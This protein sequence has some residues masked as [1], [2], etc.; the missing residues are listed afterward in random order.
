MKM[1]NLS[2]SF[3]TTVIISA[4]QPEMAPIDPITPVVLEKGAYISGNVTDT[5]G[6][7]IAE[8]VVTDGFTQAVTDNNGYYRFESKY[9]NRAKFVS[10]R[11]PSDYSPIVREGRPVFYTSLQ[12]YTG[13]ERIAN[14]TLQKRTDASDAF[15]MF[16][17]ADPQAKAY[18]AKTETNNTA[19]AAT[20]VWEDL[21]SDMRNRIAATNGN[22]YGIC[23]GDIAATSKNTNSVY[24]QYCLGMASL[25]IP[26]WQVIGNHDHFHGTA[27]ATDD[28]AAAAFEAT[29]G[30][31][32][33]SFDL[34]K[35]HFVVIDN[36]IYIKDL[37]RYPFKYGLED[38]V[39]E[40]LKGDL[41][42]VSKDTP[43]MLCAHADFFDMEGELHSSLV[44][45]GMDCRYKYEEFLQTI[46]SFGFDKMY[47][48]AG[49][50][51]TTSFIGKIN[52]TSNI[53]SFVVGRSAGCNVQ[54]YLAMDGTPR[55]YLVLEAEGKDI[56]WKY[57][58]LGV[59]EA[60][61][62][63]AVAPKYM[64][65]PALVDETKQM[66]VYPRGSYD[67]NFV[68][69]NI[70]L[71]DK[72]WG[73]PYL[74][75][76]GVDYE[77][78]RDFIYDLG[79]KEVVTHYNRH[80][81][82]LSYRGK[83]NKHGFMVR[84]PENVKGEGTVIVTDRF[85]RTWTSNVSVDPITYNDG[86][87]HLVFDFRETPSGCPTSI[88]MD[89]TFKSS[90]YSFNLSCGYHKTG[91]TKED[92]HLF[93][94]NVGS[95]LVLP[96]IPGYKLSGVTI[97]PAGNNMKEQSAKIVDK[98][99]KVV[100]GGALMKF[101]GNGTDS[102]TLEETQENTSYIIVTNTAS[103]NIGELR[104]AYRRLN[105]SGRQGNTDGFVIDSSSDIQF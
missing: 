52:S 83:L 8:A 90:G 102:W 30:P 21:F 74:R 89:V 16:M 48:W 73:T 62:R 67:D 55:G 35:F 40:W 92:N 36:C 61:F 72:H 28:D 58:T 94:S 10:V 105:S 95:S 100:N 24:P 53:E 49:H 80:G 44:Y 25:N 50:T 98:N 31:R 63:G 91:N 1:I 37:R 86:M 22:C 78:T 59:E 7:P 79:C 29:F 18:D 5:D 3:L 9:P 57:H 38:E 66:N 65:K 42:L 93:I 96:A 2:L 45:D 4:C 71:W 88:A 51:H 84:V 19:F 75:I 32:N 33:Y 41:A 56:T 101:Y 20:D 26:F 43:V 70:W 54:E 17:M 60:P 76:D 39:M 34:G 97:H 68:Y 69:A 15:T 77:M 64:W 47:I 6:N 104:L 27:P 87:E 11:V 103:F 12:D 82:S 85:G 23:L 13:M 46:D 99:G 81:A 14:I